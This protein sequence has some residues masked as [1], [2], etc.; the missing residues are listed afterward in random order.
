MNEAF[1][2][3]TPG[4]FSFLDPNNLV[5]NP[6]GIIEPYSPSEFEGTFGYRR[7][8]PIPTL[9]LDESGYYTIYLPIILKPKNPPP[10]L[11]SLIEPHLATGEDGTI[12][13]IMIVG[14]IIIFVISLAKVANLHDA[15][16]T[17]RPW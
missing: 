4:D 1:C 9:P 7:D 12:Q 15:S 14:G 3:L 11:A 16:K 10:S 13:V 2:A 8:L 17:S 5:A 6:K